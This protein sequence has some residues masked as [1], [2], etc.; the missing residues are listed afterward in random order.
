M[1]ISPFKKIK[2]KSGATRHLF[3]V[4]NH[5]WFM[6]YRMSTDNTK[7][8]KV[9]QLYD[10]TGTVAIVKDDWL[11]TKEELY[12]MNLF[13]ENYMINSVI[14]YGQT[15]TESVLML[16]EVLDKFSPFKGTYIMCA[17]N[18]FN[19]EQRHANMPTNIKQ[20]YIVAGCRHNHC[21]GIKAATTKLKPSE[22]LIGEE[23]V[24]LSTLPVPRTPIQGFITNKNKFV[25]RI[26]AAKIAFDAGQIPG[27]KE[28][29]SLQSEEMW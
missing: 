26:E 29:D 2:G 8:W 11:P 14:A 25:T 22:V 3:C 23:V 13:F 19:D 27:W 6:I 5:G 9:S 24:N 15:I 4:P 17:A 20:G 1:K 7:I 12:D 16:A 10:K 28:G 21:W 18:Y